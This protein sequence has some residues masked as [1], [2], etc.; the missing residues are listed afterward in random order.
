VTNFQTNLFQ[1]FGHPRPAITVQA[2]AV[3]FSDTFAGAVG[4]RRQHGFFDIP[5]YLGPFQSLTL[6]P[7]PVQSSLHPFLYHGPLEL[8]EDAHHLEHY[9]AAGCR[10]VDALLV[11]IQ[12]NAEGVKLFQEANEV[13]QRPTPAINAPRHDYV[14][15]AACGVLTESV[16]GFL[17]FAPLT[18]LPPV[19]RSTETCAGFAS[20]VAE[21]K[22]IAVAINKT[23]FIISL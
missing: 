2:Q 17:M 1:L 8:G 4:P 3:L 5:R 7:C 20:T 6:S 22:D 21:I 23:F 10:G 12:V 19:V 14:E 9:F 15:L 16:E 13:L 18:S 11:Q